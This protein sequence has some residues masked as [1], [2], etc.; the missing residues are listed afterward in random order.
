MLPIFGLHLG[1]YAISLQHDEI[2]E[3]KLN[4]FNMLCVKK[5]EYPT[6]ELFFQLGRSANS[7]PY[8]ATWYLQIYEGI[9]TLTFSKDDVDS[10]N[11]CYLKIKGTKECSLEIADKLLNYFTK[12]EISF[13]EKLHNLSNDELI[14]ITNHYFSKDIWYEYFLQIEGESTEPH[15]KLLKDWLCRLISTHLDLDTLIKEGFMQS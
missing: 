10:T 3:G 9:Y 11:Y 2:E 12:Y 7:E 15:N 8:S 1:T 6:M 5:I 14:K 4:N 13:R